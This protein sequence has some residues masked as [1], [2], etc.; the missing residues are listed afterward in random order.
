MAAGG[1]EKIVGGEQEVGAMRGE[2]VAAR[3]I[4]EKEKLRCWQC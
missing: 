2:G 4:C 3:R 1:T